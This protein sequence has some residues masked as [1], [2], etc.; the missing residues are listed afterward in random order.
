M[1]FWN[2]DQEILNSLTLTSEKELENQLLHK[3]VSYTKLDGE[4]KEYAI[5]Q[6]TVC[7][8]SHTEIEI[9]MLDNDRCEEKFTLV[10]MKG[11][12]PKGR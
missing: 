8:P 11:F 7:K 9:S 10:L 5:E 3:K 6:I 1:I 12:K 2:T 4:T